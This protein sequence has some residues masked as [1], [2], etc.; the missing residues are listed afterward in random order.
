MSR[1]R[2]NDQ[3]PWGCFSDDSTEYLHERRKRDRN[4]NDPSVGFGAARFPLPKCQKLWLSLP[5]YVKLD[6][7]FIFA[8][9]VDLPDSGRYEGCDDHDQNNE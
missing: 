9:A 1:F 3:P 5:A 2:G 7:P 6:R 8:R 4:R